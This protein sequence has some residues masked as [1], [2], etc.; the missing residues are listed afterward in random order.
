MVASL[1]EGG[2]DV[3]V[4][5]RVAQARERVAGGVAV[6]GGAVG[7]EFG[8][9]LFEHEPN[10]RITGSRANGSQTSAAFNRSSSFSTLTIFSF[11]AGRGAT[12]GS[13]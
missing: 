9:V 7:D 10:A 13:R 2:A 12:I 1:E 4:R 8:D 11:D 3:A 6:G 5:Q